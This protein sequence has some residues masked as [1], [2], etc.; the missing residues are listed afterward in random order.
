MKSLGITGA[1]TVR[2]VIGATGLVEPNTITVIR[3]TNVGFNDAVREALSKT[4]FTPGKVTLEPVRTWV[5]ET[6]N[7]FPPR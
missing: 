7:F 3:S 1:V 2:F 4:I 5:L 6:F